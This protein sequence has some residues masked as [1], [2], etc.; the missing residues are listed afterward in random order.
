MHERHTN[1]ERYF[2]EQA[3]TS[4]KYV[5]PFIQSVMPVDGRTSV[6]EIGC[7]EGGNL[8][9]F[10]EMGCARVVGIDLAK[11]KI[12]NAGRFFGQ[13]DH[14]GRVEFI[15]DDIYN[16]SPEVLGQFDV[17]ITRDVLEHIHGQERFMQVM[18][19]FLKP[20]GRFFLGFPPWYN[21]FGG[22]QQ[23]CESK[24]LSKTPFFHILPKPVY[25]FILKA[26]G[27]TDEKIG[28]LQEIKDT[29]ITIERF[30]RIL[31][32]ERYRIDRRTFYF[33][34]PNYEVKFGL[35]PKEAWAWVSAL[36]GLR[37]FLI[38]TNYYLVSKAGTD[39]Q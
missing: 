38:T 9:P 26:F 18:R 5:V 28:V 2:N 8:V 6:L 30:Q 34:N 22:H 31:R 20:E 32:K 29:G 10:V 36:P 14:G 37:N 23:M 17:I 24:L 27:E 3:L 35:K 12:E 4:R 7:G 33:I 1:R 15:A 11:G 25:G 19:R 16:V 21:P 39:P 13:M